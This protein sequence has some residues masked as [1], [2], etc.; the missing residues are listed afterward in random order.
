[1]PTQALS[2]WCSGRTLTAGSQLDNPVLDARRM[3]ELLGKHG[4]EVIS[5]D[6]KGRGCF[7]LDRSR[8]VDA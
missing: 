8:H 4:F 5:C 2:R 3:A 1:M 6:G 7:D